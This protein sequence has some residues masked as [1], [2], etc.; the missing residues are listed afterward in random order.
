MRVTGN[1]AALLV[2][3]TVMGALAGASGLAAIWV[4]L[5]AALGFGA[6]V[7][8]RTPFDELVADR[9]GGRRYEERRAAEREAESESTAVDG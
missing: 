4:T 3:P 2:V 9:P 7:A 8:R 1:R 6:L 5:A